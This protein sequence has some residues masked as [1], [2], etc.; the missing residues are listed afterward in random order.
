MEGR[1]YLR[2]RWFGLNPSDDT[3]EPS[4]RLPIADVCA[5]TRRNGIEGTPV[6]KAGKILESDWQDDEK[7]GADRCVMDEASSA[8]T[9]EEQED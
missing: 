1:L 4:N 6:A 9:D 7:E 5:Y 8:A 3:W 2:V